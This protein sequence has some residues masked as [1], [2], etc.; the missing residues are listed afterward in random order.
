MTDKK[1]HKKRKKKTILTAQGRLL[2]VSASS[3]V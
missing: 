1:A 2:V 3:S